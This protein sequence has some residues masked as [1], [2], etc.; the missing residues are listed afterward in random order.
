MTARARS[1]A[2]VLGLATLV[3][4]GVAASWGPAPTGLP[5]AVARTEQFTD[6]LVESGTLSS[7]HLRLY[8]STLSGPAKL[9]AIVPEGSMVRQG[10]VLARLDTTPFEQA[11]AREAATAQHTEAEVARAREE[12][13]VESLR[14]LTDVDAAEHQARNAGEALSN[15]TRGRGAVDVIAAE[16]AAADAARALA[17]ARATHDD[18]KPLLDEGFVTRP[19]FERAEQGLRRAEDQ[20]RLAAARLEALVTYERPAGLARAQAEL[21]TARANRARQIAT[22]EARVRERL[23]TLALAESRAA[24]SRAR[25]AILDDQIARGVIVADAPG[26]V[27]YREIYFGTE[28]RKPAVGDEIMPAQPILAV[29]DLARLTVETRVREVD[30]HRIANSRSIRVGFDAYPDL[31]LTATLSLVGGLAQEDAS[32]AGT[33]YFPVTVALTGSDPRLR[34][35]MTA[36]VEIEVASI[37]DALVVPAQAVFEENGRAFVVVAESGR[38]VRKP[39]TVVARNE[40]SAAITGI[41]AGERVSLIDPAA[42]RD[43]P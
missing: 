2:G 35:G 8:G 41:E 13:R 15:Q 6:T 25:I 42:R 9:L 33:R 40:T 3:A 38:T 24:E 12:A 34:S 22:A 18:M 27:V 37:P 29:P 30:L 31:M 4:L 7:A 11:R 16:T 19:E 10:E 43:P 14:A 32:R 39:V 5:T 21:T 36:R 28:P 20:H 23:A 26:M 17:E 1:R